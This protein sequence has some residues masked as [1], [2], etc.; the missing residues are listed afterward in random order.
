MYRQE[1]EFL[2]Y[3]VKITRSEMA[4]WIILCAERYLSLLYDRMH[5]ELY[6]YHVLQADETPVRVTKENRTEGSQHYMWI[7]RT[8]KMYKD[9]PVIL[10]EY[11]P[12][13]NTSHPRKFLKNFSVVCVTD[14]YQ[15]YHT[16]EEEREDLTIAGCWAHARRRFDEAIRAL[17]KAR[18]KDTLAYLALKQIQAIDLFH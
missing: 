1:Q 12:S 15:V 9:K 14:G 3:G 7:Y 8:G 2:L 17:P 18:R 4:H 6:S 16:L 5:K 10:Y 13:R 11:Q